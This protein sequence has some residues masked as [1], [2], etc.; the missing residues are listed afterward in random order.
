M[1]FSGLSNEEVVVGLLKVELGNT[2][3][4]HGVLETGSEAGN[5][6]V[7]VVKS[8]VR[9]LVGVLSDSQFSLG[10]IVDL[11]GKVESVSGSIDNKVSLLFLV[12][13]VTEDLFGVF[14]GLEGKVVDVLSVEGSSKGSLGVLGGLAGLGLSVDENVVGFFESLSG[15][16]EFLL[17]GVE[18][19]LGKSNNFSVVVDVGG[20]QLNNFVSSLKDGM[21]FGFSILSSF[22]GSSSF[23]N[24]SG[25][26]IFLRSGEVESKGSFGIEFFGIFRDT[27]GVVDN[28]DG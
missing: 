15:K 17:G 10:S 6:G 7:G 26:S 25:G 20:G 24:F 18:V 11:N 9:F 14:V 8:R 4:V 1:F 5:K 27:L 28:L 19:I 12:Q 2:E 16:V 22:S 13:S 23:S 21:S 3:S